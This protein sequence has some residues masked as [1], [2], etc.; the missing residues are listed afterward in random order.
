MNIPVEIVVKKPNSFKRHYEFWLNNQQVAKLEYLKLWGDGAE[1]RVNDQRWTLK[2][3]GFWK[4]TIEL[5]AGQ[6]PYT[7][8]QIPFKW[9]YKM[10]VSP[11]NRDTYS[12]LPKGFWKRRWVWED[13][14][15]N[16]IIELKS[17]AFSKKNRGAI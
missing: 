11:N 4:K 14:Q 17:N 12:I 15:H 10:S 8:L 7:K 3:S 16:E 13:A 6:S 1:I 9:S 5:A 2:T